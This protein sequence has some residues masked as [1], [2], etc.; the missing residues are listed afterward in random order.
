MDVGY[1]CRWRGFYKSYATKIYIKSFSPSRV[2]LSS[3]AQVKL[4]IHCCTCPQLN[5]SKFENGKDLMKASELYLSCIASQL[6]KKVLRAW[7]IIWFVFYSD[8]LGTSVVVSLNVAF[9][10]VSVQLG[11][12]A[13]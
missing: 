3:S 6:T 1:I 7:G 13:P 10:T 8:A 12:A 4:S 9:G 5:N 2:E 11:T